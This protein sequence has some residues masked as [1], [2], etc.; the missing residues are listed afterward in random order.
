VSFPR[1]KAVAAMVCRRGFA[2][3]DVKSRDCHIPF[4]VIKSV[5][6]KVPDIGYA[7]EKLCNN[8]L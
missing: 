6:V 4:N 3:T 7:E 2:W 5:N 8:K 1:I